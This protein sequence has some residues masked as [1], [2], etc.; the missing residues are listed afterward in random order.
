MAASATA[1]SCLLLLALLSTATASTT[2]SPNGQPPAAGPQVSSLAEEA[3]AAMEE[4]AYPT[5]YL[6]PSKQR[7]EAAAYHSPSLPP[8]APR[9][10][11][12]SP[13]LPPP[14]PEPRAG[15]ASAKD[16][17]EEEEIVED[18]LRELEQLMRKGSAAKDLGERLDHMA[19]VLGYL[20]FNTMASAAPLL[21][22]SPVLA[23]WPG[24]LTVF[25]VPDEALEAACPGCSKELSL[26]V[27]VALGAYNYAELT[28]LPS[29]TRTMPSAMVGFCFTATA[30]PAGGDDKQEHAISVDGVE[31]ERP[32]LYDDGRLI[33]HGMKGRVTLPAHG[34]C[35]GI[36]NK[37]LSRV[38]ILKLVIGYFAFWQEM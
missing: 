20:G 14:E 35:S 23:A 31:V 24:P 4:A 11:D 2:P 9:A 18:L 33:V 16:E 17:E 19:K 37:I 7:A 29:P 15:K 1:L 22:N 36:G 8:P 38:H 32:D 3:M 13:P 34:S 5:P 30:S 21:V 28:D 6:P 12:P 25:A 10:E 27:H 26:V